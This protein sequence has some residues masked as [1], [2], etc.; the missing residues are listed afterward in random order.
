MSSL[1][2]IVHWTICQDLGLCPWSFM[3]STCLQ[4]N[5]N[6]LVFLKTLHVFQWVL[7]MLRVHSHCTASPDQKLYHLGQLLRNPMPCCFL[8]ISS[9]DLHHLLIIILWEYYTSL[10]S[11]QG[12]PCDLKVPRYFLSTNQTCNNFPWTWY[13]WWNLISNIFL[14][15]W[16]TSYSVFFFY[17]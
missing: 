12:I 15:L 3:C 4:L 17:F 5:S 7:Y 6:F 13:I 14:P 10:L 1:N 2:Y 16:L 9:V 8:H 11:N